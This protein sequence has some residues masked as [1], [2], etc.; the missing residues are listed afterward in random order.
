VLALLPAAAEAAPEG[1][2]AIEIGT[3]FTVPPAQSAP[4]QAFCP[5]GTRAVGGGVTQ[6]SGD[7]ANAIPSRVQVGGPLD[8]TGLTANLADGD[9]ARSWF[10]QVSRG[11]L[12]G[13]GT[14]VPTA[15]CSKASDATIRAAPFTVQP[16]QGAPGQAFC[17]PGS[18]VVGGGVTQSTGQGGKSWVRANGPLDETGLTSQLADG[19]VG[20]SWFAY[21]HNYG[22]S[23]SSFVATAICSPASDAT[24][25]VDR[26]QTF[27]GVEGDGQAFCPSETRVVGG[28]VTDARESLDDV[29]V[30]GPL[31]ES[32][33]TSDLRDGDVARSWYANVFGSNPSGGYPV[34]TAICAPPPS[35]TAG[36]VQRCKD[37]TVTISAAGAAARTLMGTPSDDVIAGT[38]GRDTIDSGA[39]DD[40]V[41]A[42]GGK[43]T[44]RGGPGKDRLFGEG[45]RDKLLGQGGAD[46]LGGGARRDTCIGGKGKDVEKSC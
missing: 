37:E 1:D 27:P 23:P 25:R 31:G 15:L 10:V 14:Y 34:S 5:P 38:L 13:F 9:V 29:Q 11:P 24:I 16:D 41:C 46:L 32:G 2:A 44:V 3:P 42:G 7:P 4:G 43:D 39:G 45:G 17:P 26:F 20:R 33:L 21:V 40:L 6:R 36:A 30:S 35:T 19:D 8:E 18:R 22:T 28:G 12:S